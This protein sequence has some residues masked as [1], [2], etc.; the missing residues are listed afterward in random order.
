MNSR[1]IAYPLLLLHCCPNA[2]GAAAA[3]LYSKDKLK[4]K[5][6]MITV[7][8]S[9]LTSAV[10]GEGLLGNDDVNSLKYPTSLGV[11][12]L[13]AKQAYDISGYGPAI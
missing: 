13:L 9:V 2:D 7:A 8:A 6:K 11:Y 5:N 1:M 4:S 3:I 10:Y 12:K